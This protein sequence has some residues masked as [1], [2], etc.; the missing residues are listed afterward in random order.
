[1]PILHNVRKHRQALGVKVGEFAKGLDISRAHMTSVENGWRG[2]S[3]ELANQIA[4]R[5]GVEVDV[6]LTSAPEPPPPQPKPAP[7]PPPRRN[8]KKAGSAPKRQERRAS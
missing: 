7:K 2:A 6:L 3:I 4:D 5:L 8:E 1:M